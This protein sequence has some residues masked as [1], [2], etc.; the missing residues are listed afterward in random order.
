[1]AKE[2]KTLKRIFSSKLFLLVVFVLVI[3]LL[4]ALGKNFIKRYQ[5]NRE[6]ARLEAEIGKLETGNQ[7]LTDLIDYL[8]TDFFVEEEARLKLGL[9][10][11]GE[12]TVIVPD[13]LTGSN[14]LDVSSQTGYNEKALNNPQKWWQYFFGQAS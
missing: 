2:K 6:I 10:K 4:L 1:M 11:D 8:N 5:V 14:Q 3:F 12:N 13:S 9:S 7:E